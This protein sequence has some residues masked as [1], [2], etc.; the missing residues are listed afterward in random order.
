MLVAPHTPHHTAHHTTPRHTAPHTTP[1]HTT[2]HHTTPHHTTP[3][4]TT[5][6]ARAID[7]HTRHE[8]HSHAHELSHKPTPHDATL[9]RAMCL[10]DSFVSELESANASDTQVRVCVVRWWHARV[11]AWVE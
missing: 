9:A 11:R 5:P 2:P 6:H 4:H 8:A 1:H 10:L 7:A 3:H